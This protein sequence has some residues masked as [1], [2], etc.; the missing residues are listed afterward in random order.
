GWEQGGITGE[1]AMKG[2]SS[3]GVTR[4]QAL[5]LGAATAGLLAVEA[6]PVAAAEGDT[7]PN[8]RQ[9]RE[10]LFDEG[11]R[12]FRGDAP[13]AEVPSFDDS[14][15]RALDL[16]HDWSIEDLPYAPPADGGVTSDPSLLVPQQPPVIPGL[17]QVI[18]PFDPA[19]SA[20]GGSIGYM[21]GGIGWYRKEFRTSG[22]DPNESHVELRFD[23]V[24][25]N[26]D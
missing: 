7:A 9:V 2:E 19:N 16:P 3:G 25:Q 13:G 10:R 18:G 14:G 15:W 22:L 11:W 4:R 1:R 20:N 8:A 23:G 21:V 5:Q 17:P 6:G 26:A 12:F 24:Y